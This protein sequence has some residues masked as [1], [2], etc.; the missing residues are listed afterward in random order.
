MDDEF[1]FES[2]L[3]FDNSSSVNFD[4]DS[5]LDSGIENCVGSSSPTSEDVPTTTSPRKAPRKRRRKRMLTGVSRQR[6]AANARERNRIHGVNMA[7]LRLRD[8]LPVSGG[9]DEISKIDTL[10]LAAKWI[11][12]LTSVLMTED[13]GKSDENVGGG[14]TLSSALSAA[15]RAHIMQLINSKMDDFE[16]ASLDDEPDDEA[17]DAA[18]MSPTTTTRADAAETSPPPTTP[19]SVTENAPVLAP[20]EVTRAKS[21]LQRHSEINNNNNGDDD[22]TRVVGRDDG[23]N[24]CGLYKMAAKDGSDPR[25]T[26]PS[27]QQM[28]DSANNMAATTASAANCAYTQ[29]NLHHDFA[30]NVSSAMLPSQQNA[31]VVQDTTGDFLDTILEQ[32]FHSKQ[33]VFSTN[34]YYGGNGDGYSPWA[35]FGIGEP[36]G[37][38]L[39][40]PPFCALQDQATSIR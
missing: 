8:T 5:S 23:F 38:E 17:A 29:R 24:H 3:D 7:F 11:A 37:F 30:G 28:N 13:D 27:Q 16:I 31:L 4:L 26:Q 33:Q 12:H 39:P 18:V 22:N 14:A 1:D 32:N 15:V 10:R 40:T 36:L 34:S 21:H 20:S 25:R 2:S 9:G 35:D 6:R 19:T